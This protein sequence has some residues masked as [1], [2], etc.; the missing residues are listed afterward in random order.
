[1]TAAETF[2]QAVQLHQSGR[3]PEA[4]AGY[5]QAIA[6]KP[7]FAEAHNNLGSALS[8]LGQFDE[9]LA[10][11]RRAVA[12][13]PNL[14]EAQNNLGNTLSKMGLLDEAL[15]AFRQA[16]AVRP[17]FPEAVCN[18]GLALVRMERLEEA[19]TAFRRT[20]ELRP[21]LAEAA[22]NLGAALT[23][24][25]R[26]EEA[27]T[28]Y[29]DAL[30]TQPENPVF[31]FNAGIALNNL[32]R[33]DEAVAALRRA[34]QL[35]P[36]DPAPQ[37]TLVFI[38]NFHPAYDAMAII[39]EARRWDERYCK[40]LRRLIQAH[41]NSRDAGRR[42]RIG[43]VSP[44]FRQHVVGW[45]LLPLLRHHDREQ[46][47]V[48]CYSSVTRPDAM[49]EQLR[50]GSDLWREVALKSDEQLA[51][52]IRGDE[53][54]ILI[55]L[56]LH[57]GN[58]RLRT[59]AMAPAPVQITY[60]G[61]CGTSGV[62]AMQYRFSDPYLDPSEQDLSCYSEETIR[63]P[64]TYW[65]YA[66]GGET[67][68]PSPLPAERNGHITFGSMNQFAKISPAALDLWCE[69]LK[70][71]PSSRLLIHAPSGKY[72]SAIRERFDRQGIAAD[73]VEFI[74]RQDWGPYIRTYNRIDIG[75]DT[76]P[77][78][79]GITTCDTMWMGVPVISLSG[80]T[81]VGRGGRSILS[82]V[83]LGDLIAYSPGQYVDLAVKLAGDIPRLRELRGTLRQRIQ[84]SPLM[85]AS[86]FARH[87]EAAYRDVWR[88]W[89]AG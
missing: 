60:L 6:L 14:A 88:R 62:E 17:D 33:A 66:P 57:T 20:I 9:A 53:I 54:D 71:T 83:G 27:L 38:M 8:D 29:W 85:D 79:G 22:S 87:V 73:R 49:T 59:F 61:Y 43:Y 10:A 40:P 65:C 63:L 44:D 82:N 24:L 45:N 16:L 13:N 2:I 42:L 75:L 7:D 56:S 84:R 48:F 4:V 15:A 1:M 30:K 34:M 80:Q 37:S 5:R 70:R 21:G 51:E 67:L 68:D 18:T 26:P 23:Q 52:Q 77:Y 69:I 11:G 89:C 47:E 46:F 76:F 72:L 28:A 86:R 64:E 55:D 36:N 41:E 12:L 39:R 3:L 31:Y 25:G 74:D 81:P 35:G 50:A 78:N 32:G 19:V 58:N